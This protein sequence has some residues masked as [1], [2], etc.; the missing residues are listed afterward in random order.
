[1]NNLLKK[2]YD[3]NCREYLVVRRIRCKNHTTC[4]TTRNFPYFNE[5]D[6]TI[7]MFGKYIV[8]ELEVEERHYHGLAS[9]ADCDKYDNKKGITI[10]YNRAFKAMIGV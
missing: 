1:M 7:S 3:Q 5:I 8:I 6:T 4:T 10:A 2:L 9:R